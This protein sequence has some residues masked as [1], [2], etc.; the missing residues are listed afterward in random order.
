MS[1]TSETPIN[2]VLP[3]I[4]SEN[5]DSGKAIIY[6]NYLI[7]TNKKLIDT[8][9]DLLVKIKELEDQIDL[10]EEDIDKLENSMRYLRGLLTN[11][12]ENRSNYKQLNILVIQTNEIYLKY[13]KEVQDIFKIISIYSCILV[14]L[15][16]WIILNLYFANKK[17]ITVSMCLLPIIYKIYY[18]IHDNL[19]KLEKLN[20]TIKDSTNTFNQKIK[21]KKN[22]IKII[23]DSCLTLDNWINEV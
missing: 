19:S 12:N 17:I 18:K 16:T 3:T 21:E 22:D 15:G 23:E 7:S 14:F 6:E 11:L 1:K 8:N 2:I 5:S 13:S 9:T 10:K 4:N 20:K